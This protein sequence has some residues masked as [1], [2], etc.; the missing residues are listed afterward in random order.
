M[1]A[2]TTHILASPARRVT[3]IERDHRLAAEMKERYTREIASGRL[4]VRQETGPR[5]TFF[6]LRRRSREDRAATFP[7]ALPRRSSPTSP[8]PVHPHADWF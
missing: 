7:T 4:E 5:Q 1:G 8:R 6:P 2:L 3:L